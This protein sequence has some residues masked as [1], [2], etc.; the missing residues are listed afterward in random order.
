MVRL[1]KLAAQHA[2]PHGTAARENNDKLRER[3]TLGGGVDGSVFY[4]GSLIIWRKTGKK[5]HTENPNIFALIIKRNIVKSL[6][7]V[8]TFRFLSI[9]VSVGKFTPSYPQRPST[10]MTPYRPTNF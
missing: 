7:F 8:D 6:F 10:N 9:S 5:K 3:Q 4:P 2:A 1:E